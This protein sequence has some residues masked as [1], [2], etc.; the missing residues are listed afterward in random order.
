MNPVFYKAA[1]AVH[2]RS[3]VGRNP[4]QSTCCGKLIKTN[5]LMQ[6]WSQPDVMKFE[7]PTAHFR[8]FHKAMTEFRLL[9]E[10]INFEMT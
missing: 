6:F 3:P 9:R 4:R 1:I 10:Y 8:S 2:L 5:V 7:S